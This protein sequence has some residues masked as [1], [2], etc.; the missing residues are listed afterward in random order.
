M[1]L[2]GFAGSPWTQAAY[3]LEGQSSKTFAT[4]KKWSYFNSQSFQELIH[5]LSNSII[6]HCINQIKAGADIIQL[7]DSW[8]GIAT[9]EE[10]DKWIIEPTKYI[11]SEIK[12]SYPH[13]PI[14]GFPRMAG[15][16]YKDYAKKTGIDAI[17]IDYNTPIS[18]AKKNINIPIQGNL[19]PMLLT[20]D[21]EEMLKQTKKILDEMKNLPHIFNLGH[22]MVP[23]SK[24]EN[25]EE[26]ISF[27]KNA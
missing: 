5:I 8:A 14:I 25:I 1:S 18:W 2:I 13:I 19:D 6:I 3:I 9:P 12:K 26:L 22:G 16:K 27:I 23:E 20:G 15:V 11:T 24:I 17:S 10:H 21:K 7:F 4:L